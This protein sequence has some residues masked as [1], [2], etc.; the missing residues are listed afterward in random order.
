MTIKNHTIIL[1]ADT[2]PKELC[3]SPKDTVQFTNNTGGI[4]TLT[5][6]PGLFKD[7]PRGGVAIAD[8]DTSSEI[9]L[10]NTN[11]KNKNY[12]YTVPGDSLGTR[13]GRIRT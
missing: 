8:T 3:A 12:Y 7:F 4:T 9:T 11:N 5:A 10:L 1:P 13:T 6:D 2:D